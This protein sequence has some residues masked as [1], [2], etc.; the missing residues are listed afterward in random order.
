M[1]FIQWVSIMPPAS[2]LEQLGLGDSKAWRIEVA[3]YQQ[4][5]DGSVILFV[6]RAISMQV[7]V[8]LGRYRQSRLNGL[9]YSSGVRVRDANTSQICC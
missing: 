2:N 3:H 5:L 7:I 6:C 9:H 8:L 1:A 4:C